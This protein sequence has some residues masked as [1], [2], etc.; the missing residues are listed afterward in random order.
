MLSR[1]DAISSGIATGLA[2]GF[3]GRKVYA[4][5]TEPHFFIYGHLFFGADS[6]YLLDARPL[7]LTA[8]GKMQNYTAADAVPWVGA[9]GTTAL[10]SAPASPLLDF[11]N[12]ISVINGVTMSV[13]FD[14]HE[15]NQGFIFTGS[16]F[17]GTSFVPQLNS[18]AGGPPIDTIMTSQ[19]FGVPI[20]ND[21]SSLALG[22]DGLATLGKAF[23]S[24][25][26]LDPN[27]PSAK[28]LLGQ[29]EAAGNG[30]GALSI[31]AAAMARGFAQA[32]GLTAKL[33]ALSFELPANN[34]D[35]TQTQPA[36]PVGLQLINQFFRGGLARSIVYNIVGNYDVHDNTSCAQQPKTFATTVAE[37]TGLIKFLKATEYANGKSLF[38]VTTVMVGA[39][40]TRTMRQTFAPMIDQTGTD[41]NP[42]S[43]SFLVFG[44]GIKGGQV[45]GEGDMRDVDEAGALVGVSQAHKQLDPELLKIMGKPFDYQT[46]KPVDA[47]LDTY[48]PARYLGFGAI[49]NTMLDVFKVPDGVAPRRRF[50]AGGVV[51]PS[52]SP[53]MA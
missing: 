24:G 44:K 50:T 36:T 51:I 41:H 12:D 13:G 4:A 6:S 11:K 46:F 43:N 19:L 49:A 27:N 37:L 25:A 17:G 34:P 32:A 47:L 22:A 39:E 26:Q 16:P 18:F 40:F 30:A 42:L 31:G 9:N 3:G 7:K 20:T 8:A 28:F 14:G 35:G 10:M 48:D 23:E 53:I 5:E 15:Q 33:K 29:M 1:R 21:G 38:D 52:L 2:L 45:I